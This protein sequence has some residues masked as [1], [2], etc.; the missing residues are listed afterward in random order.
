VILRLAPREQTRLVGE[1]CARA[2]L[3]FFLRQSDRTEEMA[4]PS[5]LAQGRMRPPLYQLCLCGFLLLIYGDEFLVHER[6]K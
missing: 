2:F 4:A 1:P 5:T 3:D 6:F